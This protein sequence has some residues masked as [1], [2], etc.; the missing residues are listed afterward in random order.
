M[1]NPAPNMSTA[2]L[3]RLKWQNQ[4]GTLIAT[5]GTCLYMRE[6]MGSIISGFI[7][8]TV[9]GVGGTGYGVWLLTQKGADSKIFGCLVLFV[10]LVFSLLVITTVRRGRWMIVYDRG[11]GHP[12]STGEIRDKRICI[13]ANRV[14]YMTTRASGGSP[15]SRMV[16]AALH[17]GTFAALGP[18]GASTWPAHWAKQAAD[19]MGVPFH[20]SSN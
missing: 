16:I 20:D 8:G 4:C 14:H 6:T 15:P 1:V 12:G 7:F 17:D 3:R 9:F 10:G 19:W 2:D 11:T 18:S 5:D 13:A